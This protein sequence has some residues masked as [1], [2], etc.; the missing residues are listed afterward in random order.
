MLDYDDEDQTIHRN[1][2]KWV[3]LLDQAIQQE[4]SSM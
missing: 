1:Y 4:F 3:I 2:N